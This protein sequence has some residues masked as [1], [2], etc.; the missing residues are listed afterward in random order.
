[1]DSQ[2]DVWKEKKW[3]IRDD[4]TDLSGDVFYEALR[5]FFLLSPLSSLSES[6]F[7]PS[8]SRLLF[9]GD[10]RMGWWRARVGRRFGWFLAEFWSS[11]RIK[12][13]DRYVFVLFKK[14]RACNRLCYRPPRLE[15][16]F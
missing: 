5:I 10:L 6:L 3:P 4:E 2:K 14:V 11:R 7:P 12:N 16:R 8:P 15:S 13:L 1:M 9:V